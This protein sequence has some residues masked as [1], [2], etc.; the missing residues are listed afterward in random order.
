VRHWGRGEAR[1]G[2]G[3]GEA[4][5]DGAG[6]GTTRAMARQGTPGHDGASRRQAGAAAGLGRG[7]AG[8]RPG[9]DLRETHRRSC[10]AGRRAREGW[11]GLGVGEV[12]AQMACRQ[13]SRR[14]LPWCQQPGSPD[15]RLGRA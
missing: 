5:R 7:T 9:R 13:M 6:H 12:A 4:G 2:R 3:R 8:A 15:T 11:G 14:Q 10:A 1:P